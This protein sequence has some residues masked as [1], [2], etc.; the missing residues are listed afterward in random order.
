[1]RALRGELGR[2]APT[3]GT[4]RDMQWNAVE[5]EYS[6]KVLRKGNLRHLAREGSSNT[7][8]ALGYCPLAEHSPG[9]LPA[10]L[11]DITL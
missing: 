2:R 3:P 6:F 10:S 8:V 11:L 7:S 9:L 1:M 5:R 4:L